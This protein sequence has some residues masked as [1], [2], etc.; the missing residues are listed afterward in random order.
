MDVSIGAK[1][2]GLLALIG[3][4]AD[5]ASVFLAEEISRLGPSARRL[6]FAIGTSLLLIGA[7]LVAFSPNYRAAALSAAVSLALAGALFF[8][9]IRSSESQSDEGAPDLRE[10]PSAPEYIP[11]SEAALRVLEA[12]RD[13]IL[14]HSA[15]MEETPKKRLNWVAIYIVQTKGIPVFG[16]RPPLEVLE[17]VPT[18][19]MAR[20]RVEGGA[21]SL[22]AD[23]KDRPVYTG[24]MVRSADLESNWAELTKHIG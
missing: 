16:K 5:L 13:N 2:G 10:V 24:L 14:G 20:Y 3:A 4:V 12:N 1:V 6:F 23:D 17:Q 8:A 19:Y 22:R 15:M 9:L 7:S 11:L 18:Q 21:I